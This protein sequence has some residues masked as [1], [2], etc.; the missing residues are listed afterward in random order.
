M[1]YPD[2]ILPDYF[3]DPETENSSDAL[4][5][6]EDRR[7]GGEHRDADPAILQER[8]EAPFARLQSDRIL[9]ATFQLPHS[10]WFGLPPKHRLANGKI[11]IVLA[12]IASEDHD[13]FW[14]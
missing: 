2:R 5:D 10:C 11:K 9:F 1:D 3:L 6:I 4:I 13:E 12:A 8:S 7:L 14:T